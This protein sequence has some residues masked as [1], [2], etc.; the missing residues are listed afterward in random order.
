[1]FVL[2]DRV[3]EP[4][5]FR[6]F[7]HRRKLIYSHFA[8]DGL[9]LTN[10]ANLNSEG[11]ISLIDIILDRFRVF[12]GP[13]P[14]NGADLLN[15]LFACGRI[16]CGHSLFREEA[17]FNAYNRGGQPILRPKY[18]GPF[19]Q[20]IAVDTMDIIVKHRRHDLIKN[21]AKIEAAELFLCSHNGFI[22]KLFWN[23]VRAWMKQPAAYVPKTKADEWNLLV[24]DLNN[25][26]L[27]KYY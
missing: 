3:W 10:R 9:F 15:A 17:G 18:F 21:I 19:L 7:A 26:L 2:Q 24:F 5:N 27:R 12:A 4:I 25:K 11:L 13:P 22:A 20:D 6:F 8:Q 23:M 16:F 1:V 14:K